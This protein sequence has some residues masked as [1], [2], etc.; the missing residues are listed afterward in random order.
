MEPDN[1]EKCIVFATFV[2]AGKVYSNQTGRFHVSSSKVV[3]YVFIV[4][5]YDAN[6]VFISP[7]ENN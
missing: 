4:Y 1:T 7:Q 5:S 2:G 6:A 3:K